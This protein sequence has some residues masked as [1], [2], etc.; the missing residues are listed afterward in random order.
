MSYTCTWRRAEHALARLVIGRVEDVQQRH[1]ERRLDF[2][3][4]S[5]SAKPG[6]TKPTTGVTQK[7][8]Q[9]QM[10]LEITG[11]RHVL[12]RQADLFLG[13]AQCRRQR[14]FVGGFD[15]PARK[16]DLAGV[17]LQVR[18]ALR[19]QHR[20]SV[21]VIDD[22]H[23][24]R[25]CSRRGGKVLPNGCIDL[26]RESGRHGRTRIAWV[27]GESLQPLLDQSPQ[28]VPIAGCDRHLQPPP[29]STLAPPCVSSRGS[30]SRSS[31]SGDSCVCSAATSRIGRPS[32]VGLLGDLRAL[33]VADHRIQR[34]DQDRI[35]LERRRDARL[36]DREAGDRGV[37]EHARRSSTADRCS[38]AGCTRSPAA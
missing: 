33:L 7:P 2:A 13:L 35:A 12:A 37:G 6:C 20:Q 29:P 31:S 34:R 4:S 25:R 21:L 11:E 1:L 10:R 15:A 9:H 14:A 18:G 22:R 24:H 30:S 17:I 5:S 23:Q 38:A 3:R 32:L 28:L 36:V 27:D 26:R 19:Q 16:A 8:R